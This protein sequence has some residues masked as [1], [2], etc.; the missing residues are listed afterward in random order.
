M[1]K[2]NGLSVSPQLTVSVNQDELETLKNY[3]LNAED[4][5]ASFNNGTKSKLAEHFQADLIYN[6]LRAAAADGALKQREIDGI[7]A[8]AKKLGM[9]DEKFQDILALYKEEEDERQKRI[10]F[11][12]PKPYGET[13]AAIDHHYGR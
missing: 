9:A 7:S 13:V 1:L 4:S 2:G 10:A 3:K 11:L 12:F 8:L 6:G 5:T